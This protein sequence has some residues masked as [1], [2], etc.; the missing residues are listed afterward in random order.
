[1]PEI[2]TLHIGLS[3][4]PAL[5][6]SQPF[7]DLVQTR[8]APLNAYYQLIQYPKDKWVL[9]NEADDINHR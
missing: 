9:I 3:P 7:L 2:K 1:M 4:F 8:F 5:S 6:Q